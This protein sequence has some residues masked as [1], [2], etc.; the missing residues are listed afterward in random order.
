MPTMSI[1]LSDAEAAAFKDPYEAKFLKDIAEEKAVILTMPSNLGK[2]AVAITM[3]GR[4]ALYH[5]TSTMHTRRMTFDKKDLMRLS[6][7]ITQALA[8]TET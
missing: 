1:R 7:A 3:D 2:M 5:G 6:D 8:I 4:F